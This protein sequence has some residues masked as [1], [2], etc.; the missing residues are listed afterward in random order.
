MKLASEDPGGVWHEDLE[1]LLAE[2][3]LP[4]PVLVD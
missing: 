3:M 4:I 2:G 1:L